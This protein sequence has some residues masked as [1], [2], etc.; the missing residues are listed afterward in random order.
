M[1]QAD[2][3]PLAA[4]ILGLLRSE[5][6]AQGSRD[7]AH[8][9]SPSPAPGRPRLQ[10]P[11]EAQPLASLARAARRVLQGHRPCWRPS[12]GGASQAAPGLRKRRSADCA[13]A[14]KPSLGS[15]AG[16]G[17][18]AEVSAG[19][20]RVTKKRRKSAAGSLQP[21]EPTA[22]DAPERQAAR[23]P[24]AADVD[25]DMEGGDAG[26]GA[27]EAGLGV[28]VDVDVQDSSRSAVRLRKLLRRVLKAAAH[29]GRNGD[30]V[31]ARGRGA[32]AAHSS[33]GAP[34][35]APADGH[36]LEAAANADRGQKGADLLAALLLAPVDALASELPSAATACW[37]LYRKADAGAQSQPC[38]DPRPG[39]FL[40]LHEPGSAAA[41]VSGEPGDSAFAPLFWACRA[42]GVSPW[43]PALDPGGCGPDPEG[44]DALAAALVACPFLLLLSGAV[45]QP[46]SKPWT[47]S[48]RPCLQR[49][50]MK[51]TSV[52]P[53]KCSLRATQSYLGVTC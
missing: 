42:H 3:A 33:A 5:A 1:L 6:A 35:T 29:S 11:A 31:P 25:A 19:E 12:Q 28:N 24:G 17:L 13:V 4:V 10:L 50:G 49:P 48:Y 32:G 16:A 37:T 22:A 40:G 51:H 18:V 30:T 53:A 21:G 45:A 9:G 39:P 2:P 38:P 47:W 44:A 15:D 7:S 46:G 8:G 20:P 14:G 26:L 36:D 43:D 52:K 34:C 41:S 27:G 23:S